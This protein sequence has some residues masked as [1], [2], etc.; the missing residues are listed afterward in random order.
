MLKGKLIKQKK[1]CN[2]NNEVKCK[3]INPKKG[4]KRMKNNKIPIICDVD[5]G[6]DDSVAIALALVDDNLDLKMLTTCAGN[7]SL[8]NVTL[9]TLTLLQ[10]FNR[11]DVPVCEGADKPLIRDLLQTGVHGGKTGM[12]TYPFPECKLKTNKKNAIDA[13]YKIAKKNKKITLI[14]TAPVTNLALLLQKHPKVVKYIDKVVFQSGLL[15]DPNYASFNV[16]VDP[17]AMQV[18]I[19]SG[20]RLLICPSDMGHVTCLNDEEVEIVR[21]TNKTGE[22]FAITFQSYRD[23]V[24][25][26]NVAM[27]DSCAVACL[28]RPDLFEIQPAKCSIIDK[29]NGKKIFKL[30]I[31]H[32]QSNCECCTSVNISAFKQYM[33]QNLKKCD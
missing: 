31:N 4:F 14:C 28:S 20:V 11:G 23:R 6:I 16:T 30:E 2:I 15:T 13:I 17:E 19:D 9:N 1:A 12:G 22:M 3:N 24:C 32:P 29:E 8:S 25:Q 10:W 7:T 26:N 33:L 21:N 5:T 18:V 27:H